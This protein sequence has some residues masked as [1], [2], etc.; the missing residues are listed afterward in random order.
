METGNDWQSLAEKSLACNSH[1]F[2]SLRHLDDV[3]EMKGVKKNL[4]A[5]FAKSKKTQDKICG[6]ELGFVGKYEETWQKVRADGT[7]ANRKCEA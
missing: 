3:K 2:A 4:G 5:F 7:N 1:S 6:F